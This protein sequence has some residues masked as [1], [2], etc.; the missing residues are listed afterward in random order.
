MPIAISLTVAG[1]VGVL[2]GVRMV[3]HATGRSAKKWAAIAVIVVGGL[4]TTLG[5]VLLDLTPLFHEEMRAMSCRSQL[6]GLHL[7]IET[8]RKETGDYP[9]DIDEL[10]NEGSIDPHLARC[11]ST[12]A[13]FGYT[14]PS[15]FTTGSDVLCFDAEV[16]VRQHG[17]LRFCRTEY[18]HVVLVEGSVRGFPGFPGH[19]P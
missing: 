15:A 2:L 8:Y 12:G 18:Y 16:H 19:K 10:L 3:R 5:I 14:R 13:P 4:A 7:A 17:V 11:S 9:R 6:A 1:A